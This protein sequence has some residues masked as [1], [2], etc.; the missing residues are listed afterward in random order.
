M[1]VE[2]GT[3]WV[4]V[5]NEKGYDLVHTI[6]QVE[7]IT[8]PQEAWVITYSDPHQDEIPADGEVDDKPGVTWRGPISLFLDLFT[9]LELELDEDYED[10]DGEGWKNG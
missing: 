6:V 7:Q 10:D 4:Y 9:P 1:R 3:Q 2:N 8:D 5:G